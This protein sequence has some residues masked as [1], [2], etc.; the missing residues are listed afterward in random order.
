MFTLSV[1][2]SDCGSVRNPDL[3]LHTTVLIRLFWNFTYMLDVVSSLCKIIFRI[4]GQRSKSYVT[5]RS[6]TCFRRRIVVETRDWC[7]NVGE[8]NINNFCILTFWSVT[9]SFQ[10]R[11]GSKFGPPIE[12][13]KNRIL[14]VQFIYM[15]HAACE[16][17]QSLGLL[18]ILLFLIPVG[19]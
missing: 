18:L 19:W 2:L 15:G 4:L 14:N 5:K 13:E 6:K 10:D 7:Q 3:A 8:I 16:T 11:P 17:L 12:N 9:Y 1:C